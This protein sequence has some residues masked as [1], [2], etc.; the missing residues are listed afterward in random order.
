MPAQ[1]TA[2]PTHKP[3]A[4]EA[5]FA[6]NAIRLS[7]REWLVVLAI[8]APLM[9][10]VP[11]LWERAETFA[12]GDNCRIPFELSSDYWVFTRMARRAA[13]RDQTLLLGDSVF[14]GRY[15]TRDRT[16]AAQLNRLCGKARFANLGVN[17]MHPA[18]LAG[19]L[20]H[21]GKAIARRRVLLHFNLLWMSS[22]RHDLRQKKEF[23][24]NHPAL[25]PQ[26]VP[27][28]PCYRASC[29]DRIGLV[30]ERN[31]P[32]AAWTRHLRV[33]CF[34]ETDVPTWTLDHPYANPLR[35]ISLAVPAAAPRPLDDQR[36]WT[37]RGIARQNFPWVPLDSSLQW[38]LLHRCIATLQ[39]R[40]NR[41][42][43]LVGPFNEHL[44]APSSLA[45]YRDRKRRVVAWL[46]QHN[47]PHL[48]PPPLPSRLYAD[49]SHPVAEGY[50]ALARQLLHDDAFARFTGD[51]ARV[52][53][54]RPR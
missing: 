35:Q 11:I 50:V 54:P 9:G 23:R 12:P 41:V 16:L 5:P 44:L 51:R 37:A 3:D 25:V 33:A 53:A 15:V 43:V 19:L 48:A 39:R 8:V 31:L 27:H 40:G 20:E 26:F 36:P 49:A 21:Y 24:F 6:A 1:P 38:R 34:A 47:I 29:A 45:A 10:L 17:G 4:G 18:A 32:F 22:E 28:I 14:W 7:P 52:T 2:A 13:A 46:Q 42:F 30:I